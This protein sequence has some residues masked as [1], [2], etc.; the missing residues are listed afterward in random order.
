MSLVTASPAAASTYGSW[1]TYG[2]TNPITVSASTWNCGS[3]KEITAH[4]V[5]QV[6]AIRSASGSSTQSAVIVRNNRI[7]SFL[8]DAESRLWNT[9]GGNI[10]YWYCRAANLPSNAW[11][12]CFGETLSYS[13]S[14][15]AAG[16]AYNVGLTTS[17]YI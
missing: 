5:A 10:G 8:M 12:V 16:S 6:C 4:V 7:S 9:S 14:V 1:L 2:N 11:T 15:R 17:P 3:S 13:S